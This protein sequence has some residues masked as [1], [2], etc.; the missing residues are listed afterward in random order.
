MSFAAF[1]LAGC[2]GSVQTANPPPV[3]AS[4][5]SPSLP[6]L[7]PVATSMPGVFYVD[8][9]LLQGAISPLVY[10][11]NY[12]PWLFVTLD[13]KPDAKAAHL[14]YLRYPGG[15]WGDLNDLDEWQI[16]QY[17][18]LC[19][20]LGTE[21]AISVRL[22]DSTPEKAVELLK[23][24]NITKGYKVK[25][26]SIGNEPNLYPNYTIEK[27][28][29]DWRVWADAMRAV[30]PNIKLVGPDTNQFSANLASN[31]KD[32]SGK[33]WLEEFLKVNGDKVDV[34]AVHRYAFPRNSG[35]GAPSIEDLRAN[36]K[37]WDE[38]IPALRALIRKSAKRDIPIGVLEVNSSWAANS[39]SEGSMDSFYNAIWWGDSLGRMI[40][41]GTDIVAQFD[42]VGDYGLMDKYDPYP[43]YYVY[44]MY[45]EFG[46]ERLLATSSDPDLSLF[47]SQRK[48]G[49]LALMFVNL[50]PVEKGLPLKLEH[51]SSSGPAK[52]WLFDE[53]HK[54]ENVDNLVLE[55][56]NI[57]KVPKQSMML[58]VLPG[59]VKK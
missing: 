54:A 45:Q 15:N 1:G 2:T 34:V 57:V 4:P 7:T 51:F 5:T 28:N 24:V 26:W 9:A 58:V 39:G 52:V 3:S 6:T 36:S 12:G 17:M 40:R 29:Q 46:S 33:D 55:N 44:K 32:A 59:S 16:D 30:D 8:A 13:N 41:Q 49:A 11:S 43:I 25:Y 19:K 38:I 10:G 42:L 31:P 27:F 22:K 37:E 47:A 21:P 48:D 56:G 35:E 20:E 53:Q 50:G 23:L 14:T 18:A